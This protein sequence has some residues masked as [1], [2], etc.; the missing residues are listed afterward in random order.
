MNFDINSS[1]TVIREAIR[2]ELLPQAESAHERS[3]L[4]GIMDLLAKLGGLAVWD[5]G[6]QTAQADILCEGVLRMSSVVGVPVERVEPGK[7]DG[8]GSYLAS[9]EAAFMALIDHVYDTAGT[10]PDKDLAAVELEL[11][12]LLQAELL[13]ERRR[14]GKSDYS[15]LS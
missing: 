6:M 5:N 14:I 11:I 13:V 4:A 1:F 10:R 12:A 7:G 9:A 15:S 3:Q 8:P 2:T